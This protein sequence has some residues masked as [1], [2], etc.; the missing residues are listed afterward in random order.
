MLVSP[1]QGSF[2]TNPDEISMSVS[3]NAT[4]LFG[5]RTV[6]TQIDV[7]SFAADTDRRP[8]MIEEAEKGLESSTTDRQF[9][10]REKQLF[11][12]Y[13]SRYYWDGVYPYSHYFSAEALTASGIEPDKIA[14]GCSYGS[15][16]ELDEYIKR[17]RKRI[18]GV[19]VG[20]TNS[21]KI[22][23]ESSKNVN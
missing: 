2:V 18:D 16:A 8:E 7:N 23:P 20:L 19:H 21:G 11:S 14:Y 17:M 12:L 1:F 5:G 4:P 13:V 10:Q 3:Y 6:K 22:K 15:K 9:Q